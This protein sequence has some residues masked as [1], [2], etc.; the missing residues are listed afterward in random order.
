MRERN[1]AHTHM[2][3]NKKVRGADRLVGAGCGV[4]CSGCGF[5]VWVQVSLHMWSKTDMVVLPC[6]TGTIMGASLWNT[7]ATTAAE[8]TV[9]SWLDG[10]ILK[11]Q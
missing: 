6:T 11:V 7:K 5:R 4:G 9:L 1:I 2:D 3:S 10:S 8:A